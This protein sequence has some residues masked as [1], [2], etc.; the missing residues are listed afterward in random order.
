MGRQGD[1]AKSEADDE[2]NRRAHGE[3]PF[4]E[5]VRREDGLARAA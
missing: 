4:A 2:R 1:R 5:Q 3:G